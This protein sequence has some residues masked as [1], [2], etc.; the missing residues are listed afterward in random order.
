MQYLYAAENTLTP[1]L[2]ISIL[3]SSFKKSGNILFTFE[4]QGAAILFLMKVSAFF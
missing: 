4:M 3:Y 2:L 1:K